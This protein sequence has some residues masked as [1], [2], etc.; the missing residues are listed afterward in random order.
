MNSLT[1]HVPEFT[2]SFTVM[3]ELLWTPTTTGNTFTD[4]LSGRCP[5]STYGQS[6]VLNFACLVKLTSFCLV[7]ILSC[8]EAHKRQAEF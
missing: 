3:L 1:Q 4:A 2:R 5:F 8:E 6:N 7:N